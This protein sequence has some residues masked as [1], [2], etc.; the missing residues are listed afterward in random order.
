MPLGKA[1]PAH[2]IREVEILCRSDHTLKSILDD[3]RFQPWADQL[4]ASPNFIIQTRFLYDRLMECPGTTPAQ[5][6][7]AG[8][9]KMEYIKVLLEK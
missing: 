9:L 7:R 8:K 4:I 1:V 6:E 5:I 3:T 2:I